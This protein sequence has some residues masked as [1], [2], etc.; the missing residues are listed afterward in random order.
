MGSGIAAA[1]TPFALGV[2]A[3]SVGIETAF[4]VLLPLT[5]MVVLVTLYARHLARV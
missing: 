5:L 2:L 4:G 1:I 3:D